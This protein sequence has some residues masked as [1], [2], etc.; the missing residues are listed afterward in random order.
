MRESLFYRVVMGLSRKEAAQIMGISPFTV[1]NY[2][3]QALRGFG[4]RSW[5]HL[6]A[7]VVAC[8]MFSG[9]TIIEVAS[10]GYPPLYQ[11]YLKQNKQVDRTGFSGTI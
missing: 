9:P 8:G 3:N 4:A 6:A 5:M 10:Q 11:F 7:L 2:D 1:R